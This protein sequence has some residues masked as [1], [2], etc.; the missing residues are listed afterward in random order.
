MYPQIHV[1]L[2][3]FMLRVP[4]NMQLSGTAFSRLPLYARWVIGR[5]SV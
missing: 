5:I 1:R 3:K 2:A 4:P